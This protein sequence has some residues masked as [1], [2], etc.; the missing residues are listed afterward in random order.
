L[1]R[2]TGAHDRRVEIERRA[3]FIDHGRAGNAER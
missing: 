1:A 3:L 2:P